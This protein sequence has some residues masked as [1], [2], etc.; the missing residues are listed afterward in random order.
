MDRFATRCRNSVN[1]SD[2]IVCDVVFVGV[3]VFI[4]VAEFVEGVNVLFY[5][6][7]NKFLICVF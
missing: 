3:A 4:C 5:F 7:T 1:L 6:S 2:V